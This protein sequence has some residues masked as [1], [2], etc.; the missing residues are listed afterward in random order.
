MIRHVVMWKMLD[1]AQGALRADNLRKAKAL[2]EELPGLIPAIR[3][4]QAGIGARLDP[5]AFDLV[6][7]AE[8]ASQETL[9]SY[10]EHPE[11]QRVAAFLRAVRSERTVVDVEI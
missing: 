6:L 2:L 5:Q 7:I 9:R 1:H 10:L 8:F 4:L 3:S 11:H